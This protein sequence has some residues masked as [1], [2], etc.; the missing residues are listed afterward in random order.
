[1]EYWELKADDGLILYTDPRA[2]FIKI[3][4]IPLH[5]VFQNSSIPSFRSRYHKI[6]GIADCL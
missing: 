2:I 6:Y 5:P 1:M 4:P 3:D